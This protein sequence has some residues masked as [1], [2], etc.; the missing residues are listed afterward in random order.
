[1]FDW[2]VSLFKWLLGIWSGLPESTKEKIINLIV[3]TFD[4]ILRAFYR[5]EKK[6][7]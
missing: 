1:M 2:L 6:G 5:S 7:N 4:E 3:E